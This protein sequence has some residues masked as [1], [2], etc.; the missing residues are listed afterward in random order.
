MTLSRP[1]LGQHAQDDAQHRT[2]VL[3]HRDRRRAGVHH[4]LDVLQEARDVEAP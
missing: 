1:C 3:L 2:G 4:L